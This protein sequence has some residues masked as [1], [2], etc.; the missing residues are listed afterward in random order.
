MQD[1]YEISLVFDGSWEHRS[2]SAGAGWCFQEPVSSQVVA[3]GARACMASSALHSELL[4]CFW[5]LQHA[6]QLGITPVLLFTDCAAIPDMLLDL[7]PKD[8]SV[9]WI[10]AAIRD[11]SSVFTTCHIR[12][13]PRGSVAAAH[14]LA[15]A[16]RR[17]ELLCYSF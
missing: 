17:R 1:I 4:A 16:A 9:A 8:I 12:K 14:A 13:V 7:G 2:L 11:I 3:G 10:L 15:G 5:G 6:S